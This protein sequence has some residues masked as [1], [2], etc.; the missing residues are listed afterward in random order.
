M[1]WLHRLLNVLRPAR[2]SRE[3]D[4]ELEFHLAER[5]D[6]L[7]ASGLSARDAAHEA[8]RRFG[9]RTLHAEQ[10]REIDGLAWLESLLADAR[11]AIR[12]LAAT[13]SFTLVAIA[14]LAL[15]IGANTAIFSLTNALVLK[16]LP[17]SRPEQL[18]RLTMDADDNDRFTNPLWEQVRDRTTGFAEGFAYS[19]SGF[20]LANGGVRRPALGAWVSGDIFRVLGIRPVAGRLLQRGDDVRGCPAVVSVST[21]F[22]TRAYGSA[23]AAVGKSLALD[24]HPFEISGVVEPSFF[25]IEVGRSADIYVPL[26]ALP[27][28]QGPGVLD[29]RSRWYLNIILRPD[30]E[31]GQL[32]LGAR[33]SA[34]APQFFAATLPPNWSAGESAT[35]LKNTLRVQPVGAGVSDLRRRYRPA[36]YTLMVVVVAVLLIACANIANLLLARAAARQHE[37]AIRLAIGASRW[38]VV[39]QLLTESL[40]LSLAGAALG[41]L[42]AR[43]ASRLLVGFLSTG[44]RAVSL[45][46]SLDWRVFLFTFATA[47]GTA[48]LFGLAPAWLATRA[49]PQAAL[50]WGGRGLVSGDSRHRAGRSLVVV[51]VALSLALV[52]ASGLLL[53]SFRKLTTMDPGFRRDGVLLVSANLRNAKFGAARLLAVKREI[54]NGLR[55]LPGVSAASASLVTPIGNMAWNEIVA[56]QGYSP[57]TKHDSIAFLNEVSEGYFFTLGTT[58][59]AGRDVSA[60]D[61]TQSRRVAVINETMARRFFGAASAIGR[62]FRLSSGDTLTAP[63]EVAGVVRDAK[64]QRLD[65]TSLATA[66]LPLGQGDGPASE[67]NFEIRSGDAP[68]NL[69]VAVRELVGRMSPAIALD[70]TTLSAQVDAS[71][72]RPRLL[73]TLSGFF[74]ALALLLAVIGLYGTMSY[75]VTRR[76]NEIGIRM[77]LGAAGPRVLRMVV[78]EA[79]RL[80]AIGIVCGTVLAFATTRLVASLL[81]GVAP[82]DPATFTFAAL[83]MGAAAMAAAALPAWRA[84]RVNPMEA[85]REQ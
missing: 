81:Y 34:L 60:D 48:V 46:L 23:S 70:F 47:V 80:V 44:G 6:E 4:R 79:G 56:V 76:R 22:A 11:Y 74:G 43:W 65:E 67:L 50:R 53:G 26:C 52:A 45:D 31:L 39:R 55:T 3:L 36:L 38:R 84:G 68:A 32:R 30:A 20:D 1:S 37:F 35:Y 12:A 18:A 29:Q 13:P 83:V 41:V 10:A 49:E 15:G 2:G 62:T 78:G 33:L 66:Y 9:N 7:A 28:L 77:A 51:Q 17:V 16:S 75:N 85:L 54:L 8:R 25:G 59:V 63:W 71:L 82:T 19:S 72:T 73:A 21:G 27:L 5:T 69:V 58:V 64:Y 61:I 57:A 14:S 42:F 24:G 40:L